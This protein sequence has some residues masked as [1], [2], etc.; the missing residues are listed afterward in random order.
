[1]QGQYLPPRLIVLQILPWDTDIDMQVTEPTMRFLASYYNMTVHH[2]RLPHIAEGR[3]YLLEINPFY[4]QTTERDRLN[5]IDARW[6]DTET[7]LFI[8]VTSVRE[9]VVRRSVGIQGALMVKDR[10]RYLVRHP[11]PERTSGLVDVFIGKRPVSAERQRLRGYAGQ[12]PVCVRR[13]T[14]GGVWS[15]VSYQDER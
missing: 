15:G 13:H 2:H 5:V 12:D 10:H 7:G 4:V 6:I 11:G 9:D 8:D 14:G 1:M 3:D